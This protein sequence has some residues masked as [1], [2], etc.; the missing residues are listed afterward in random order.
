MRTGLRGPPPLI[1]SVPL[2]VNDPSEDETVDVLLTIPVP[3]LSA[4]PGNAAFV[5]FQRRDAREM[6]TIGL[7]VALYIYLSIPA[8]ISCKDFLFLLFALVLCM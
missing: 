2:A 7:I 1:G 6:N 3:R 5:T 8:A 4:P